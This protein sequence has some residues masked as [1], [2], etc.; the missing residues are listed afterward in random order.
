MTPIS[1]PS[2]FPSSLRPPPGPLGEAPCH[3]QAQLLLCDGRQ[4]TLRWDHPATQASRNTK[5]MCASSA[6]RA[7]G[8][9]FP[10]Q[11]CRDDVHHPE[12]L[13]NGL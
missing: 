8:T 4:V 7:A 1:F 5:S 9:T 6:P 12:G 3:V 10:T 2:L 11:S 13:E